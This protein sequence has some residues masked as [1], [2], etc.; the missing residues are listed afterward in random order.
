MK[1]LSHN[2][3]WI[4]T[5]V[6]V[7][8]CLTM[9]SFLSMPGAHSF[10]VYFDTKLVADQYVSHNTATPKLV[11]NPEEKYNDMKYNECGRT[12]TSRT[13]TLKDDADKVLKVWTFEGETSGYKDAMTCKMKDVIALKST[14]G[15]A[16]KLFY[17]SNDFKEGQLVALLV[18]G[19]GRNAAMN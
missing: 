10:Q 9:S 4:T 8:L 2:Y 15:K 13:L 17:S 11:I 12:V 18:I 5:S 1:K 14:S 19:D 16:L 6:V 7:I 3:S